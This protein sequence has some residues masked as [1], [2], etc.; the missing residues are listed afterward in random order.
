MCGHKH[1]R[2]E[3]M[4]IGVHVYVRLFCLSSLLSL[5]L[6]VHVCGDCESV[7]VGRANVECWSAC[8]ATE[9]TVAA[10]KAVGVEMRLARV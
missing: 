1:K 3:A 6:C 10:H 8:T 2:R 4:C 5:S 7:Y 9:F